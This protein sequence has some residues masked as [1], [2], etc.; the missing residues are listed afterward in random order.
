[1]AKMSKMSL[2]NRFDLYGPY[3]QFLAWYYAGEK[4]ATNPC[5][6]DQQAIGSLKPKYV[7]IDCQIIVVSLNGNPKLWSWIRYVN[8]I[9]TKSIKC[10]SLSEFGSVSCYDTLA[11]A[12]IETSVNI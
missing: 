8:E 1:M 5:F 10:H 4:N 3:S 12:S 9:F 7:W 6:S 11:P 2:L